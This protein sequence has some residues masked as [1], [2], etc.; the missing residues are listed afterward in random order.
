MPVSDPTT[1]FSNR[2]DNYVRYRPGYPYAVMEL[3]G[4][5][6]ALT[7]DAIVADIASGTGLLTR[8]FLENGNRVFAVEPNPEMRQAGERLLAGYHKFVSVAGTAE[9]TTLTDHSIDLVTAAQAAH[10]FD[11][12]KARRE[13][14]RILKP[15]GWCALI[16]NDRRTDSSPFL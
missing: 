2:V 12:S 5:E 9:A 3:L 11:Q 8:I 1:R 13:F 14:V 7:P 16:W 15:G 6:C 4:R 10:W